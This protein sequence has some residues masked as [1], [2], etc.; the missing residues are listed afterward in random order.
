LS[1]IA[2]ANIIVTQHEGFGVG[3]FSPQLPGLVGGADRKSDLSPEFLFEVAR[4]AGLAPNG[5]I[6]TFMEK[7]VEVDDRVFVIRVKQDFVTEQR[8][9][10]AVRLENAIHE[11]PE[12]RQYA[13]EDSSE[14]T[15]FVVGLVWEK[16]KDVLGAFGPTEPATLGIFDP[17]TGALDVVGLL[18]A[19]SPGSDPSR[20]MERLGLDNATS[21]LADLVR[22]AG[23]GQ[24]RGAE[25]DG[26]RELIPVLT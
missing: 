7:V 8:A 6:V 15:V 12:L 4:T 1:G 22:A 20:S 11:D 2:N 24:D 23:S 21:S 26:I 17:E 25:V 19:S 14:E 3:F 13:A 10:G 9:N 16:V 18:R 5:S